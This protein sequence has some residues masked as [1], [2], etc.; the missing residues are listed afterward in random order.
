LADGLLA[1]DLAEDVFF[2]EDPERAEELF[3]VDFPAAAFL[4]VD[5]PADAFELEVFLP[6]A[7]A[8]PVD[9]DADDFAPADLA[10]DDFA[11]VDLADDDFAPVDL[12]DEDFAPPVAFFVDDLAPPLVFLAVAF[13]AAAGLRELEEL[14]A[15]DFFEVDFALDFAAGLAVVFLVVDDAF[16]GAAFEFDFDAELF[17]AA[18]FGAA[19]FEAVFFFVAMVV[20]PCSEN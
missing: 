5:L 20:L 18:F 12:A 7:F 17:E 10:A 8:A 3:A 14:F 16:F 2:A 13:F 4:A 15:V 9:L 6:P 1:L 19:F 11:P